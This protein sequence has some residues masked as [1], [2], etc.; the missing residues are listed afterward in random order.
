MRQKTRLIL[1]KTFV[2]AL[3]T[4]LVS[5]SLYVVSA[6]ASHVHDGDG[7]IN[8]QW[9]ETDI[10]P[11]AGSC[12]LEQDVNLKDDFYVNATLSICLNGHKISAD[13]G[14]K[15]IVRDDTTLNIFDCDESIKY[16]FKDKNDDTAYWVPGD[17]D[18]GDQV[19]TGGAITGFKNKGVFVVEAGGTL[20]IF[21]GNIVGNSSKNDTYGGAIT[22]MG[23][24]DPAKC[25][26]VNIS[27]GRIIGNASFGSSK[28]GA[29]YMTGNS[30]LNLAGGIISNNYT[31]SDGGAIYIKEGTVNLNGGSI[32]NNRASTY[33]GGVYNCGNLVMRNGEISHNS[34]TNYGAGIYN[35]N[36]ITLLGG[37]VTGNT[38]NA[39]AAMY[40]AGIFCEVNSTNEVGGT[41]KIYNNSNNCSANALNE[42]N[43]HLQNSSGKDAKVTLLTGDNALK[44]GADVRVTVYETAN[45]TWEP[46]YEISKYFTQLSADNCKYISMTN[47]AFGGKA[48]I[49]A[50]LYKV[51]QV[52]SLFTLFDPNVDYEIVPYDD[53][54]HKIYAYSDASLHTQIEESKFD[55]KVYIKII[56]KA[57]YSYNSDDISV[58]CQNGGACQVYPVQGVE[59]VYYFTMPA[60]KVYFS[61]TF[62]QNKSSVSTS[63]T[64]FSRLAF[65]GE[66]QELIIPGTAVNGT[67]VY[68]LG[69]DSVNIPSDTDA[70]WSSE[71]PKGKLPGE[72]Y[73]WYKSK[74]KDGY[75]DSD[76]GSLNRVVVEIFKGDYSYPSDPPTGLTAVKP[77]TY[78]ASDGK[79]NG[80]SSLM[81]YST[82]NTGDMIANSTRCSDEATTGLAAG[83]YYV[84]YYEASGNYEPGDHYTTIV[85]PDGDRPLPPDNDPTPTP[86]DN[87]LVDPEPD[88][89]DEEK[90][91][92]SEK[93]DKQKEDK[94][95]KKDKKDTQYSNGITLS[96]GIDIAQKGK[97]I[98]LSWGLV[99]DADGY[100][101]YGGYYGKGK[102]K[103]IKTVKGNDKT[104]ISISKIDKKAIDSSKTF[105]FYVEAY[106]NIDGEKTSIGKSIVVY[107]AGEK[108]SSFSDVI[109]VKPNKKSLEI[110]EGSSKSIK[111]TLV[112]GDESKRIF[113]KGSV[114]ALRFRSSD[115]SIATVTSK[116]K[117]KTHA[118]G[119]CTVYLYAPNGCCAEVKI[120]VK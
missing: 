89:K 45:S 3:L 104:D 60:D 70:R 46:E 115:K 56:P 81:C 41:A 92:D 118:S 36:S 114:A 62:T 5:L 103:L 100:M 30:S 102:T 15:I 119:T 4:V 24:T 1:L 14:V 113:D 97:K 57:G 86:P 61:A 65:N 117:I 58:Y 12:Y 38:I 2:G 96:S 111:A 84:F 52:T 69:D 40:G 32:T 94:K 82:Q 44:D 110:K 59:D 67:M 31:D 53:E 27:G 16:Y 90:P 25:A 87:N 106:K 54:G 37:S 20:N 39:S 101:I 93:N 95:D 85:I 8:K 47:S 17:E 80:T 42:S 26:T 21:G 107:L 50:T 18:T 35:K 51:H 29:I 76:I 6:K 78:G 23:G 43:I 71:I 49:D 64:S 11:E 73:I 109:E 68:C 9:M 55:K 7:A 19:V 83:T 28:G 66:L 48:Q 98:N 33:G 116:G 79:I 10:L 72:Y 74:G 88:T 91:A 99:D 120:V 75:A 13:E 34:A 22:L 77:S 63:P 105:R 108:N 112:L